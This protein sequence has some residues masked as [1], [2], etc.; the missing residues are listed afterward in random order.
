MSGVADRSDLA[1]RLRALSGM[2]R[3]LPLLE[4]APAPCYLVGGAVRDLLMGAEAVDLDIAVEGDAE[5][6]AHRLAAGLSGEVL[7]HDRFGTAT[8]T[9]AGL[10]VDLARTRR[11]TYAAPGA[12]PDVE[13]AALDEDLGRRDFTINAMALS[14]A[15]D[16][17][18]AVRDPHGGR[19]DLVAR[20]VRVLHPSSFVDDPTRL[21]RAVRYAA[22]L[23][24]VI[25]D[26][27][28]ALALATVA[29]RALDTVS[30]PR[31]R[32]EL[33]DLLAE[34]EAPRGVSLL[35]ELGLDAA[36]HPALRADSELVAAAKLGASETGAR[37]ELAA[38]AA[39]CVDGSRPTGSPPATGAAASVA[40]R[41]EGI[42]AWVDGLGLLAEERDAVLRA[43]RLAPA[44][45]ARLDGGLRPSEL[46][47]L[48]AP[49]PPEALALA[50]ALGAPAEPVLEFVARLRPM[51][52]E[53]T[54]ADLLAAGVPESPALGRA[55]EETL[56][57]KL[58]GELD[59]RDDELRAAIELARGDL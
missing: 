8:V 35:A 19:D 32:D 34:H 52:L 30:G 6:V 15:A 37:P 31:I 41:H 59:G 16:E 40:S 13:P 43:A 39:F 18:G 51:R 53:I 29:G 4:G 22:R 17:L 27:T 25:E 3:V 2:D 24:F 42:A 26:E 38:L 20:L 5:T 45:A 1:G 50:L 11:E 57:R 12:L 14:L 36:L 54:G 46:H 21:L 33:I 23:G 48:L 56:A 7:A 55:L 9:A 47:A 58:D 10:T 49:E 44:L 28:R